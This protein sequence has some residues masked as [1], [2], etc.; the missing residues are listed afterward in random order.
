MTTRESIEAAIAALA[1]IEQRAHF[2]F[3]FTQKDEPS[4]SQDIW[5]AFQRLGSR[6][7]STLYMY[8][9]KPPQVIETLERDFGMVT[10]HVS[11]SRIPTAKE[12]ASKKT[13]VINHVGNFKSASLT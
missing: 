4:D 8:N 11:R 3:C 7:K 1:E 13:D 12:L 2:Y 10:G 9:D 5:E 6:H